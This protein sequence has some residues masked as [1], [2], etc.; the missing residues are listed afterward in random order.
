M[1]AW[2]QSWYTDQCDGEWEHRYGVRIETLDN[3]G[4]L[5]R[6]DLTG[7]DLEDVPFAEVVHHNPASE[8]DWVECRVG[9]KEFHGAGGP[10]NL[11][12][13]LRVFRDWAVG[14]SRD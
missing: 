2:L 12:E 14:A 4:W 8:F 5:I 11:E 13:L 10:H 7:T 6:I 1:L 3:P 9:D